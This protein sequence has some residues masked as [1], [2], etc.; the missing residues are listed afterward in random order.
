MAEQ[1]KLVKKRSFHYYKE[2]ADRD[3]LERDIRA[4]ERKIRNWDKEDVNELRD[5]IREIKDLCAKFSKLEGA[6]KLDE[7]WLIRLSNVLGVHVPVMDFP[8]DY[9]VWACDRGGKCL[10]G[11]NYD[12]VE[13][14]TTISNKKVNMYEPTELKRK[15]IKVES[16][17]SAEVTANSPWYA[18][19]TDQDLIFLQANTFENGAS[20]EDVE[21]YLGLTANTIHDI[22]KVSGYGVRLIS[23]SNQPTDWTVFDSEDAALSY[24]ESSAAFTTEQKEFTAATE[25]AELK[26]QV[27]EL[28]TIVAAYTRKTEKEYQIH[29]NYGYGWEEVNAEDNISDGRRSLA[30]YRENDP[31]TPYKM[32][33][34]RVPKEQAVAAVT[35]DVD[36][37][38]EDVVTTHTP[39][40]KQG[41]FWVVDGT[42][43]VPVE[44]GTR[45]EVM[46]DFS[47]QNVELKSGF[48]ALLDTK[49]F[50]KPWRLFDTEEQAWDYLRQEELNQGV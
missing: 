43:I 46:E 8:R 45:E 5:N 47:S 1:A 11:E 30:E 27:E 15:E 29:G 32:V 31:K 4:A 9:N 3:I 33:V 38:E 13:K 17:V 21:K 7:Q 44:W 14:I 48:G 42:T 22:S 24:I 25:I 37:L 35:A 10:T 36:V 20:K 2:P 39:Q 41:D 18:V 23:A 34:K 6:G 12:K 26:K 50:S 28:E 40:V 49:G 16:S 19:D